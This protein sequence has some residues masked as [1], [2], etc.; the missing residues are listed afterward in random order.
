MRVRQLRD[1]TRGLTGVRGASDFAEASRYLDWGT[2]E[3]MIGTTDA[4]HGGFW[5]AIGVLLRSQRQETER[6][7]SSGGAFL[8]PWRKSDVDP[9]LRRQPDVPSDPIRFRPGEAERLTRR[10]K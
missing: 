5:T 9:G 10:H 4:V 2:P 3:Y 1:R 6:P 8:Q 7:R